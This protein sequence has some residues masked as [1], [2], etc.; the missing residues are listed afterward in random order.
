MTVTY[1]IVL[2]TTLDNII[3]LIEYCGSNRLMSTYIK[4]VLCLCANYILYFLKLVFSL[5]L[6][7]FN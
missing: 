3:M 5:T 7:R 4:R 6:L 1:H 2:D